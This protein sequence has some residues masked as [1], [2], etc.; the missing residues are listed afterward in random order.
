MRILTLVLLLGSSAAH[1]D[2]G[3]CDYVKG[4]ASAD[5][6]IS[7]APEVFGQ[8]GYVEQSG[9]TINPD[10]QTKGL[11]FI[12]G[13]RYSLSGIY[14]GMATRARAKAD[15]N[16]HLAFEQVKGETQY[17]AIEAQIKVLEGALGEAEKLLASANTE[18]DAR[19]TTAQEVNATR[20]RVDDLRRTLALSKQT[21]RTIPA[22]GGGD[23]KGAVQ[24]Y[25]TADAEMEVNEGKLRRAKG[26]DVS[27]RFGVDSFLDRTDNPSPYFA[28]V[29][30]SINLGVLFQSSG[31]SRAAEG[32]TRMVK[33]GRDPV[34]TEVVN[35]MLDEA[36]RR[37]EETGAL[38]A[39][40]KKQ[41]DALGRIAGDESKRYRVTLWFD[42]IKLSAEHAYHEAHVET[43]R[44][45]LGGGG[46]KS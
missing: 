32:R 18:Y 8:F 22:P 6:A 43:L 26:V 44:Q 20:L 25:A 46:G 29:S 9:T 16:R 3:Y 39:D 30:A 15:C 21:L 5:S 12:G 27:V 33:A 17:R 34:S 19:R 42:W 28:V 13:L 23:V 40:L 37:E 14:E 11:R 41:L 4:A 35:A 45:V 10:I 24:A 36:T 1:A 31:N 2:D 7:L 38:A